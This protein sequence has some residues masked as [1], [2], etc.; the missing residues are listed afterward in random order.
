M[1]R[2]LIKI[3]FV[4]AVFFILSSFARADTLGE[5]TPFFV[6]SSY[7]ALDRTAL[8]ATLQEVSDKAYFYTED[9]WWNSLSSQDSAK[10]AIHLLATE[11]DQKIYPKLTQTYGSLWEPGIDND[12][13]VTILISRIKEGAGGYFNSADEY[14]RNSIPTSNEREIIYLNSSYFDTLRA[15]SFLAH[16]F[17]HLITFYQKDKLRGVADEVWLNEARSEYASTLVG[18]DDVFVGSNLEKR[19]LDFYKDPS[20]SLTEWTNVPID[21]GSANLFMQYL[22]N[23]F[24]NQILTKIVQNPYTGIASINE[25]FKQLGFNET[26]SDIFFDWTAANYLNDCKVDGQKYCYLNNTLNEKLKVSPTV[27]QFLSSDGASSINWTDFI[28]DWSGHWYQ[29]SGGNANLKINFNE[30]PSTDFLVAYIIQRIN[31]LNEIKFL[32]LDANGGGTDIVQN[33]GTDVSSVILIPISITNTSGF[34]ISEP[35]REFSYKVSL[36]SESI[37]PQTP[38]PSPSS[39]SPNYPDGSLIRA[40]GDYKVYIVKG[41]YKRW[42]QSSEIF[43]F[44]PHL[45]WQAVI[46]VTPEERDWYRDAWLVR[47]DGDTKVYEING[48]GTKHWLNMTA[49]QFSQTG[50]NW[51]MVYIINKAERDFYK[52]GADVMFK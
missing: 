29:F 1:K 16:E 34:G 51:N 44:Y 32:N 24:G 7:D 3:F 50:R 30:S 35:F 20:D 25:A 37:I 6:D 14:Q 47:A 40:K 52:I 10:S 23:H 46:E 19:I 4:S 5:H 9:N 22:V 43:K 2:I 27:S 33:F 45:G 48:D 49:E 39:V 15:K 41:G 28:K 38:E 8:V 17:Q 12:Y 26:F 31:G 42:V 13:K 18:Y 21:Y 11:F 36:T